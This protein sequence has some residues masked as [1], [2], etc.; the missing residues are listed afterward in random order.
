M[1]MHLLVGVTLGVIA[2]RTLRSLPLV[3]KLPEV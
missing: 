3:E 1:L 2:N